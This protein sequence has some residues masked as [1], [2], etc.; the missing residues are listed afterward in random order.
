MITR[1]CTMCATELAA[2]SIEAFGDAFVAHCDEAHG[3]LPFPEP[4]VRAFGES[5]ARMTGSVERLD[6]LGTVEVHR[7]TPD[8]IDDWLDLFD[9]RAMVDVPQN[10]ACYCLEPHEVGGDEPEI[11][12]PEWRTRREAMVERLRDGRTVGYLAYVDGTAAGWV[13]ASRRCDYGMFRRGD[14]EDETT[15]GIACFAIAPPYR[16]HG[17]S[18][19]LLERVLADAAERGATAVE[20]YPLKPDD[21]EAWSSFRGPR[22]LYDGAGFS[23]VAVRQRDTVVRRTIS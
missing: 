13:N 8:R 19:S 2:E 6:A 17:L 12:Y 10:G 20:A 1:T 22:S 7:V 18:R 4:A 23:E 3:D 5:M 21:G 15:I 11:P 16:R 9:H 14:A